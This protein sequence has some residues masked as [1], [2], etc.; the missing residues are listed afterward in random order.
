MSIAITCSLFVAIRLIESVG[1]LIIEWIRKKFTAVKA[2]SNYK[3]LVAIVSP[4]LHAKIKAHVTLLD[5]TI[6]EY[7]LIAVTEKLKR[8]TH[9]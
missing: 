1:R 9:V 2:Q 7:I 3:R 5:T 8:E 6:T 4:E